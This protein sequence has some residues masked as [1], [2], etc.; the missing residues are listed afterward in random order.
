MCA[1]IKDLLG[2]RNRGV[3]PGKLCVWKHLAVGK[4]TFY[5]FPVERKKKVSKGP[6]LSSGSV[7]GSSVDRKRPLPHFFEG[8]ALVFTPDAPS[9]VW[10]KKTTK[11]TVFKFQQQNWQGKLT[12]TQLVV[13]DLLVLNGLRIDHFLLMIS[14][15]VCFFF[16]LLIIYYLLL[17][18]LCYFYER[19][20]LNKAFF[21][22][23]S[24]LQENIVSTH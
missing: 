3:Y 21:S 9:L 16:F 14:V 22:L 6:D 2:T 8:P 24:R 17:E 13:H 18:K 15:L 4:N 1:L 11:K 23:D 19:E 7:S 5:D 20:V 10:K 12:D